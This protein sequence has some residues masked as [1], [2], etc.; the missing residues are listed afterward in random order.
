MSFRANG[1]LVPA[2]G[3]DN[4][5]LIR[6][7]MTVGRRDTCD[8]P[9]RF[10]NVS[11]VHCELSFR[12]GYWYIRDRGSTNGIKVNGVRVLEKMLHPKD[13]ITIGKRNYT[14]RYELPADARGKL[15]EVQEEDIMAQSLLEKAGL[16]K[17]QPEDE[18]RKKGRRFD[19]GDFLL[20]D[21]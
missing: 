16:E 20:D 15:E 14:I 6:D 12:N 7:Q 18:R 19:P 11:G 21:D 13:T 5:P 9:L 10:P 2:G 17:P 8:I 3:G 1:E 4:I